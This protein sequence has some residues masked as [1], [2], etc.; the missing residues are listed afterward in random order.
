MKSNTV[1]V[2]K[3][4]TTVNDAHTCTRLVDDHVTSQGSKNQ[5]LDRRWED[6]TDQI[7]TLELGMENRTDDLQVCQQ[8]TA[9]LWEVTNDLQAW[10]RKAEVELARLSKREVKWSIVNEEAKKYSKQK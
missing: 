2:L 8:D 5:E 7:T 6:H 4:K 3:L 10:R 1:D 9:S